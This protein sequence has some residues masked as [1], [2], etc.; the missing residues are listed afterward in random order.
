MP[1]THSD[2]TTPP[3]E[4]RRVTAATS[5]R[6][7]VK[8]VRPHQW[9]KNFF[10]LAPLL[11]SGRALDPTAQKSAILAFAVFCLVASAVYVINDVVDRAQDRAH[12]TKRTRPI[13]SGAIGMS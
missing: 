1:A 3:L 5:T 11:F 2:V 12:P 4:G 10:V 7:W 9:V 8:L 13:A 6:A